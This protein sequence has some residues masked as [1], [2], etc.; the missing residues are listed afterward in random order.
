MKFLLQMLTWWNNQSL[1]TQLFTWRN[2]VLVG[3]DDQGNKFYTDKAGEK[4]WVI[5]NGEIEASRIEPD[6]HGWL[7]HTFDNTPVK[8]PLK[9]KAWEKPHHENLTGT[10]AAY[11]PPGSMFAPKPAV[12]QDY[13]SWQP[14]G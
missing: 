2:G 1:G 5:F 8:D 13:E 9:H 10:D 7:H 4:R 6:W 14:E 11:H 12:M 3:E